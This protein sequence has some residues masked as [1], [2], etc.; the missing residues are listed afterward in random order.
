MTRKATHLGQRK[1]SYYWYCSQKTI[2]GCDDI[3]PGSVTP[4]L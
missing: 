2:W 1:R 3:V 4:C